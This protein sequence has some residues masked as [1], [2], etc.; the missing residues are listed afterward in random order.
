MAVPLRARDQQSARS[1]LIKHAVGLLSQQVWCWGRDI[2]RAD[3]NWLIEIGFDRI[4]PPDDREGCSSIYSLE[5]SHGRCIV[6]RGFG[7]FYGDLH[8]GGIFLPRYEF[9]PKYTTQATL[10]FLPWSEADLPKLHTP[11]ESQQTSCLTLTSD[12]I[13]WIQAYELNIVKVLGI[14]YRRSILRE[15][16]NGKRPIIP[17][18]E[19]AHAWQQISVAIYEDFRVL[20]PPYRIARSQSHA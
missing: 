17:A 11:S 2:L 20:I 1:D 15:W 18:E 3:G 4:A 5:L 16:N 10:E 7:V 8:H 9:R 6:L 14:E 19:M 13:E 12:L